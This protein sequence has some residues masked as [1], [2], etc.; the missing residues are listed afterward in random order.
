[1]ES[2][3]LSQAGGLCGFN[4]QKKK[5]NLKKIKVRKGSRC[6]NFGGFIFYKVKSADHILSGSILRSF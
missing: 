2:G 3:L 4:D 5:K 1:M 6:K